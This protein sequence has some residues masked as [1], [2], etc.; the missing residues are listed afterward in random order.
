MINDEITLDTMRAEKITPQKIRDLIWTLDS[1]TKLTKVLYKPIAAMEKM[2]SQ[3]LEITISI[4]RDGEPVTPETAQMILDWVDSREM[5]EDLEA[6]AE[7]LE[8]FSKTQEDIY[9][10]DPDTAFCPFDEEETVRDPQGVCVR[11]GNYS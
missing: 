8:E 2:N 1:L 5:Q 4:T 11:C 10:E 7:D 3:S 9:W 6:L